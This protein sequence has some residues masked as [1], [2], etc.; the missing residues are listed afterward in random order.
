MSARHTVTEQIY[1]MTIKNLGIAHGPDFFFMVMEEEQFCWILI[2]IAMK[3]P[4]LPLVSPM[5]ECR[6]GK[7]NFTQVLPWAN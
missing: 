2:F 3:L 1:H 4:F 5:R 7:Q 6:V